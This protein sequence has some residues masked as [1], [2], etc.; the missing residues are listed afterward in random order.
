MKY[1]FSE[2]LKFFRLL[3]GYNQKKIAEELGVTFSTYCLYETGE[4]EPDLDT[5]VKIAEILEIS[6]DVLLGIESETKKDF[7]SMVREPLAYKISNA[8][9]FYEGEYTVDE[10]FAYKGE[11]RYE[12]IF[13]KL[14]PRNA[15]SVKHQKIVGELSYALRSYIKKKKGRCDV[16]ESPISVVLDE[17]DRV[18]V[19]PDI[20]VVCR[21]EI[22]TGRGIEGAPDLV[23]E[24]LSPSTKAYDMGDKYEIYRKYD[25]K[26]YL[27]I[28]PDKEKILLYNLQEPD[29]PLICGFENYFQMPLFDDLNICMKEIL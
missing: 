19:Q 4:A 11:R 15:P 18:V 7:P 17:N 26:Y 25:V 27:I 21:P 24:V 2:N 28:D 3:N 12:L 13:G 23:V 5:L 16:F 14:V 8:R 10:F 22:I 20:L 29:F 1:T 6:I 9:K